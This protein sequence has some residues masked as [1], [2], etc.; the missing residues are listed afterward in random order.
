MLISECN[1]ETLA[2]LNAERLFTNVPGT[3]TIV[4]QIVYK[5]SS[6]TS[7]HI[8]PTILCKFLRHKYFYDKY[9][10]VTFTHKLTVKIG[11]PLGT[12]LILHDSL[13]K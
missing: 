12:I 6:L 8:K 1:N 4:M 5:H 7:A 9:Y 10:F 2:S 11:S 3:N 13:R